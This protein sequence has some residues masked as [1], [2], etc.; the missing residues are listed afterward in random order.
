M[1]IERLE[2]RNK[3]LEWELSPAE[4]LP[5]LTLLVGLSGVGKTRILKSIQTLK[6]ISRSEEGL[7]PWGIEWE[8]TFSMANGNRYRWQGEFEARPSGPH[9]EDASNLVLEEED[10]PRQR[11]KLL[12][13]YLSENDKPLVERN[14]QG[15]S[16]RGIPTPKLSQ[17]KS[18]LDI[19]NEED[20]ISSAYEG[21]GKI[22]F[23]EDDESGFPGQEDF[24]RSGFKSC[25]RR[26]PD[27][28]S[29]RKSS[30]ST[31]FK[32]ALVHENAPDI[33]RQIAQRFKEVFQEVEDITVYRANR[34]GFEDFPE[35]R[36]K[37][38][39]AKKWI[40]AHRMSSGML[41]TLMHLSRMLLWPDGTVVL[42]DEFENSLGVNCIDF[43]T[44]DLVT[45]SRRLQFI[46]TSHHPYIINNISTKHWKIVS[47]RGS[48]VVTRGA[49][50]LGLDKSRHQAFLQLLNLEEYK[51]GIAAP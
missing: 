47:R 16:L 49:A 40:P 18:I 13:E 12:R 20:G 5:D 4:F 35:I 3:D 50:D 36:I 11:P 27:L 10:V 37:E 26:F 8:V 25:C 7:D 39:G 29:I 51:E 2:Y 41:R 48:T 28:D 33:F 30:W 9:S 1:R 17:H 6:D 44:E 24:F 34:G 46:I 42:I 14:A 23:V 21:F 31:S 15:I 43:V 32:L 38:R 19:L 45:E 22:L